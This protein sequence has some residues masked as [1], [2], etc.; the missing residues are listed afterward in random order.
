MTNITVM[1]PRQVAAAMNCTTVS[2]PLNRRPSDYTSIR[3]GAVMIAG[4]VGLMRF[5]PAT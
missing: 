3:R 4:L 5:P 1:H 2:G